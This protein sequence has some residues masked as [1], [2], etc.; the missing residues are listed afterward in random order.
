VG[1]RAEL[2]G[3][4]GQLTVDLLGVG[5][6]LEAWSAS[7]GVAVDRWGG[8]VGDDELELATG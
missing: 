6:V 3:D 4:L 7:A 1:L 8:G 2:V 5:R